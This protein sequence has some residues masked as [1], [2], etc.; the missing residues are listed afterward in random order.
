MVED[1]AVGRGVHVGL[2]GAVEEE[3]AGVAALFLD[4]AAEC[5]D[6]EGDGLEGVNGSTG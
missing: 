4:S 1:L 5:G 2:T 6:I 3:K